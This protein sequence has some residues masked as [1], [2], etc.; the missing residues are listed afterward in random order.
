MSPGEYPA[1]SLS[2]ARM[3][4]REYHTILRGGQSPIAVHKERLSEIAQV[5]AGRRPAREPGALTMHP[6]GSFGAVGEEWFDHWNKG[7]DPDYVKQVRGWLDEDILPK[8]GKRPI[9]EIDAPEIMGMVKPIHKG[10]LSVGLADDARMADLISIFKE[11]GFNEIYSDNNVNYHVEWAPG[12][13]N[14]I[15]F[16]KTLHLAQ[17]EIGPCK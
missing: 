10:D 4:H 9:G 7:N 3:E 1:T 17:C 12:H 13:M 11:N 15:H 2:D 6:E 5:K 8:L 14:H 16:G